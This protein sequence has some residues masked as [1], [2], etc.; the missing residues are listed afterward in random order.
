MSG[1]RSGAPAGDHLLG[2]PAARPR[3]PARAGSE[4]GVGV[5]IDVGARH[6]QHRG[7]HRP[8]VA[9]QLDYRGLRV[10]LGQCHELVVKARLLEHHV[11][12]F[13]AEQLGEQIP[14][15]LRQVGVE[16]QL[17][18]PRATAV[19]ELDRQLRITPG[20]KPLPLTPRLG[21]HV[22]VARPLPP[23][24]VSASSRNGS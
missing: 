12:G 5:R 16:A 3:A 18:C 19:E 9:N 7:G 4:E 21:E 15:V 2:E 8:W 17:G 20:A 10:D 11:L 14:A 13:V 6:G 1:G 24:I 23:P 22:L